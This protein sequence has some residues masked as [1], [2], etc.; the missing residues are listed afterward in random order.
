MESSSY[1]SISESSIIQASI[2]RTQAPIG[3]LLTSSLA[4]G[5]DS[6]D[7]V[8]VFWMQMTSRTV[9]LR[10]HRY[11]KHKSIVAEDS[12]L[13]GCYAMPS[14]SHPHFDGL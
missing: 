1:L 6:Q 14:D 3:Q 11:K 12:V 9:T 5:D 8:S 7:T 4:K 2:I 10:P 13:L